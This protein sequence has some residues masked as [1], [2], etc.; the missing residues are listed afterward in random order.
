[1]RELFTDFLAHVNE[2]VERRVNSGPTRDILIKQLTWEELSAQMQNEDIHNWMQA[3]R[4]LDPSTGLIAVLTA[5]LDVLLTDKQC[6]KD[7]PKG[8][9]HSRMKLDPQLEKQLVFSAKLQYGA[10][11]GGGVDKHL[12]TPDRTVEALDFGIHGVLEPTPFQDNEEWLYLKCR[13]GQ[14]MYFPSRSIFQGVFDLIKSIQGHNTHER[15]LLSSSDVSRGT[16][17]SI[18]DTLIMSKDGKIYLSP[19]LS[20]SRNEMYVYAARDFTE[21][22]HQD[23][24]DFRV[25]HL[26][27]TLLQ[28]VDDILLT[29]ETE[30]EYLQG[31]ECSSHVILWLLEYFHLV[32]RDVSSALV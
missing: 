19:A 31:H 20:I 1:P 27:L 14:G 29:A 23:L 30:Q 2:T 5:S 15:R 3:T 10:V 8:P 24:A 9:Q 16:D 22:L 26:D 17:E 11:S 28:Y 18:K 12:S 4:D 13:L 7:T 32:F 6:A 25:S 21:A